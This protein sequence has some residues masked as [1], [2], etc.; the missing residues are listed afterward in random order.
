MNPYQRAIRRVEDNLTKEHNCIPFQFNGD[1]QF[2]LPGIERQTYTIVTANSGVGK[3]QFTDWLVLHNAIEWAYNKRND[4]KPPKLKIFYWSLEMAAEVKAL[5]ILA[6]HLFVSSGGYDPSVG[7]TAPRIGMKTMLSIFESKRI[8]STQLELLKS[9]E[10]YFD[11]FYKHV[12]ILTSKVSPYGVYKTLYD[13][14]QNPEIGKNVYK[15]VESQD[16]DE[17]KGEFV[18]TE[19]QV[20]DY[21]EFTDEWKD[22]YVIGILDHKALISQG[23]HKDK[24]EA[25]EQLSIHLWTIRNMF[26]PSLFSVQQQSSSQEAKDNFMRPT[27]SGLGDNKAV[28]RDVDYVLGLF[29]PARAKEDFCLGWDMK[30]INP[31]FRELSILKSRYGVSNITTGL[32]YDGTTECFWHLSKDVNQDAWYQIAKSLPIEI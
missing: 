19:K 5:Q 4:E 6:H 15:T 29:D 18:V 14:Y 21:Y 30:K 3:S 24:R 12:E 11:W 22:G 32:F 8:N 26:G 20:F 1:M 25:M 2:Y 27:L 7:F 28:G 9:F 23:K 31:R 17:S 13:F 16:F 10:E